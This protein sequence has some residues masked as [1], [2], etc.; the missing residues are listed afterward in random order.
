LIKINERSFFQE[1]RSFFRERTRRRIRIKLGEDNL[2][3]PGT[4]REF[5][6]RECNETA[7]SERDKFCRGGPAENA[8]DRLFLQRS[9]GQVNAKDIS[10]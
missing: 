3:L 2:Q 9:Y 4:M 5:Q 6:T 1:R 8:S 7:P 10:Q